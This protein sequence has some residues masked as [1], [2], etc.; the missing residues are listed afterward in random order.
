[1]Q[2]LQANIVKYVN[3]C[4]VLSSITFFSKQF[5]IPFFFSSLVNRNRRR[6]G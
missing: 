3:G 5:V 6:N 2:D 1:M 4:F